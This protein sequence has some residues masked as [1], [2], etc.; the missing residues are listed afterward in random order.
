LK[1]CERAAVVS[2]AG[3]NKNLTETQILEWADRYRRVFGAWPK[4]GSGRIAGTDSETWAGV[5]RVLRDGGKGLPGGTSLAKFLA[6]R[7]GVR[8]KAWRPELTERQVLKW[9]DAYFARNGRWPCVKSGSIPGVA[10]GESWTAID[11]AMRVGLRGFPGGSSLAMLLEARRNVKNR[12]VPPELTE[13]TILGWA[14]GHHRLTG[15]WPT[16]DSGEIIGVQD[17]TWGAVDLALR[18]GRRGLNGRSSLAKFLAAHRGY[19]NPKALP[20]L[21]EEQIL[22]WADRHRR[23]T[24]AWPRVKSGQVAGADGET[25]NAVDS[26]LTH[27][28]RGLPGG[29]SLAKLIAARRKE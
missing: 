25:W 22:S 15:K 26:A 20:E 8:L 21:T 24:G 29:S 9:A 5:N 1:K 4:I 18:R 3:S 13:K 23:T 2:K 14:D 12:N 19:R 16:A 27:G 11:S 10:Y 6:D 28:S 7:R 17:E